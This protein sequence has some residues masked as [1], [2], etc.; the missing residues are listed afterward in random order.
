MLVVSISLA[1]ELT[2]DRQDEEALINRN[3]STQG[4]GACP[5]H[6]NNYV[7]IQFRDRVPYTSRT[8]NIVIDT[9]EYKRVISQLK[10]LED[11][12]LLSDK[13]KLTDYSC[14][15]LMLGDPI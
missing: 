8:V 3:V 2:D 9:C 5:T 15:M 13:R 10:I 11:T 7:R 12:L 6:Y 14:G 4:V 1:V